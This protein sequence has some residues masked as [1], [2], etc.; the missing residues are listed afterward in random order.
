MRALAAAPNLCLM[1]GRRLT[2]DSAIGKSCTA[3]RIFGNERHAHYSPDRRIS[4]TAFET[5][6]PSAQPGLR[7][8]P[9]IS[10]LMC[11]EALSA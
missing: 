5:I 8:D 2:S 3:N 7:R 9:T 1:R 4:S 11:L 6:L 10:N